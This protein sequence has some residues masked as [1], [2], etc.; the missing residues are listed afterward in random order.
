MGR[1][2]E[3]RPTAAAG[4]D[5]RAPDFLSSHPATPERIRNAQAN[6]R[7]YTAPGSGEQSKVAYLAALDGMVYGE[8]PS[9]GYARGRRF[10]HP[11]L[12][13]TFM[14]P[15]GFSLD[16]TAQA[17]L[18]V[19]HGG[20]QALRLDVV[21]VPPEQSLGEYLNSG[22]IENIEP[23]SVEEININGFPAA[24]ASAKGNQWSFRLYAIRF[25]SEVYRFIFA[26]KQRSAEA[27][28]TFRES[29]STFR[30]MSLAEIEAAR[31]LRMKLVTVLPGDTAERFAT[32]MEVADRPLERFR[33]LNGLSPGQ[34]PKPGEKVKIVVE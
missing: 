31:P 21:R 11:R 7:Q 23:T 13:F 1:N 27:D 18:G 16:N 4:G 14:A 28:R 34:N 24:T 29:V 10:L 6:A 15:E 22:W 32:R 12:G 5:L 30:R 20:A 25:G 19:R 8:D 26:M 9:Q 33:V 3:M 17:V 2:A